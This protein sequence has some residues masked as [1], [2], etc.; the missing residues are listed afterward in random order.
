MNPLILYRL[1][2]YY[3]KRG[4]P[5]IPAIKQAIANQ[6]LSNKYGVKK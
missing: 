6:K 3:T 2:R 4:M 1:T 5:V